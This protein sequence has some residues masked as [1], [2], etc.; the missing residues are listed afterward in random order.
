MRICQT[1]SAF[2][3]MRRLTKCAL[4]TYLQLKHLRRHPLFPRQPEHFEH[5]LFPISDPPDFHNQRYTKR[6]SYTHRE[7]HE[8]SYYSYWPHI[9]KRKLFQQSF[10]RLRK[11][12][13]IH[14][15]QSNIHRTILL[16]NQCSTLADKQSF[17][18]QRAS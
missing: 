16:Q 2:G 12:N 13:Q 5:R 3:Q 11:I 7:R 1:R 14:R 6:W 15:K 4:H 18:S 10:C 17:K 9:K 8:S